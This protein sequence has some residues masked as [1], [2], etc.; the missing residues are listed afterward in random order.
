MLRRLLVEVQLALCHNNHVTI[1]F[2]LTSI[3]SFASK[4]LHAFLP[5]QCLKC[6]FFPP[7]SRIQH[8]FYFSF[9]WEWC[10]S[11][12]GSLFIFSFASFPHSCVTVWGCS[13]ASLMWL[14]MSVTV[15]SILPP[16]T[17]TPN[18]DCVLTE[19][20]RGGTSPSCFKNGGCTGGKIIFFPCKALL[21]ASVT[22]GLHLL[23]LFS[24]P[25]A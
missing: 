18:Y 5:F 15:T 3:F 24:A 7:W 17:L 10:H 20:L 11:M 19:T 8:L 4:L 2:Y 1:Y 13:V 16:S 22:L 21:L 6:A 14:L 9:T 12:C 25:L 23:I